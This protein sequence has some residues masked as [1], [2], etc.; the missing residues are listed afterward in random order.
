MVS[1]F[2]SWFNKKFTVS[3]SGQPGDGS[4]VPQ[5]DDPLDHMNNGN[6]REARF[7]GRQDR[8]RDSMKDKRNNNNVDRR[9]S[10]ALPAT[11]GAQTL[12]LT[13]HNKN[14]LASS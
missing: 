13:T 1:R 9:R 7:S 11:H 3:K 4:D 5:G 6:S 10:N 12:N 14:S 8:N 2:S